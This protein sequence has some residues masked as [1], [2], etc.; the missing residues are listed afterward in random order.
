MEMHT[1]QLLTNFA[2]TAVSEDEL[3]FVLM[4]HIMKNV[5]RQIGRDREKSESL[6][7]HCISLGV[8]RFRNFRQIQSEIV[9]M[10]KWG[11]VTSV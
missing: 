3:F 11:D 9:A 5:L 6:A 7:P 1:K 2:E 10:E 4:V 8:A